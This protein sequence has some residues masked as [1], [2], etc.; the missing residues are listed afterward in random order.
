MSK[1]ERQAEAAALVEAM[2]TLGDRE[3][4][5]R[6]GMINVAAALENAVK[7]YEG[8]EKERAA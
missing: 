7:V 3:R 8:G 1:E 4:N 2:M 6:A 5:T